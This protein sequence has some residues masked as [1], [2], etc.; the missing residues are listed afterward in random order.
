M[1]SRAAMAEAMVTAAKRGDAR[2]A[3]AFVEAVA[4]A[5]GGVRQAE[6]EQL[7]A[8]GDL[9]GAI[10][11]A[12]R[13][14]TTAAASWRRDV[15]GQ[16]RDA[17]EAGAEAALVGRPQLAGAFDV[18]NPATVAVAARTAAELVIR[19]TTEQRQAIRQAVVRAVRGLDP[20][21]LARDLRASLGL[22]ARGEAAL[23]NFR[24][25][26]EAL[27]GEPPGTTIDTN[28]R[29]LSNRGLTAARVDDLV[30]R[31][32]QRL[33]NQRATV[34]ARTEVMAA[35]NEGQRQLWTQAAAA[36]TLDP[37]EVERVWIVTPDEKL[38]PICEELDGA[39][40]SLDGKFP[41]DGGEG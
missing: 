17:L 39:R 13:A 16:L 40:A 37:T 31:Y 29:R 26:L 4:R 27:R 2:V 15:A 1:A 41:G 10:A 6:L 32:R 9:A 25:R 22:T 21:R 36:G 20:Q 8:A 19:V 35:V 23:A 33:I 34:I 12:D 5:L 30:G 14:W 11:L 28:L 38:C 24:A 18:T 3:R 7:I